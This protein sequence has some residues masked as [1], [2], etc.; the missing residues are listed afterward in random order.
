M[1]FFSRWKEQRRQDFKQA[2]TP[3]VDARNQVWSEERDRIGSEE[4]SRRIQA[5]TSYQMGQGSPSGFEEWKRALD[6]EV[7]VRAHQ[8]AESRT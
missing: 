7:E 6:L 5:V 1:G 4:F 2:T 8:I 3:Y